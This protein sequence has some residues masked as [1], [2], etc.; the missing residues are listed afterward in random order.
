VKLAHLAI[1]RDGLEKRVAGNRQ[2]RVKAFQKIRPALRTVGARNQPRQCIIIS[3]R[4]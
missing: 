1:N 2:M 4:L 3:V